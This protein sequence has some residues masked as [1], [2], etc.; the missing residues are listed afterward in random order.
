MPNQFVHSAARIS[1]LDANVAAPHD[2]LT[3]DTIILDDFVD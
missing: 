3:G 2:G 1:T